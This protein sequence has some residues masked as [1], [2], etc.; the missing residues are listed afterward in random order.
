MFD[1]CVQF[2]NMKREML[3]M[4]SMCTAKASSGADSSFVGSL[5]YDVDGCCSESFAV[6]DAG[7]PK[8]CVPADAVKSNETR[9]LPICEA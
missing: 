4:T 8:K 2:V 9:S 5:C 7:Q 6:S 3:S 1:M